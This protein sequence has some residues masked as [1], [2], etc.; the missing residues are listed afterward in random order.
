MVLHKYGEMLYKGLQG[1]VEEHLKRISET[2]ANAVDDNFLVVLNQAWQD[3]KVSMLMIRDILMYMVRSSR[4][5]SSALIL[6]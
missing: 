4:L 5:R 3:H 1:V 6:R 2:V